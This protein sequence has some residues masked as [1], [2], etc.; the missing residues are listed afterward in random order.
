MYN[1]Y[2][3]F[4]TGTGRRGD[5]VEKHV[6]TIS[7]EYGSGGLDVGR[8]LAE[9][10]GVPF[11][12]KQSLEQI[13][14]GPE[15]S[16]Q[17]M[18]EK[19]LKEKNN[20]IFNLVAS[21]GFSH[22]VSRDKFDRQSRMLEEIYEKGSCVIVGRCADYILREKPDV[23]S[24]FLFADEQIRAERAIKEYNI[25]PEEVYSWMKITDRTRE[26]Y[27]NHYTGRKWGEA[28]NY[29]LSIDT[30]HIDTDV[31]VKLIANYVELIT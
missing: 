10:M 2:G 28:A 8:G 16:N 26:N 23:T 22:G 29:H 17:E 12:D 9:Y 14:G 25:K 11:Y 13:E 30:A 1:I 24:I 31:I 7:R 20:F 21:L 18:L 15:Y 27:Y 19:E 5:G 3:R 4:E 6:I